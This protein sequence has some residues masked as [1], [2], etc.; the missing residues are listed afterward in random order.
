MPDPNR[1]A[2][3]L[4]DALP[5]RYDR[6]AE[7]LSFGQN[8]RWRRAMCDR[9]VS[10]RA[11]QPTLLLDVASG[12]AGVAIQLGRRSRARIVG[13]DL[14]EPMLRRGQENV[15]RAGM[16]GRVSLAVGRAERLPFR[17]ATFEGLC[18]T[19]LLRYVADPQATLEEMVR[20][21][22][23]GATVASLEFF[24]PPNG[25]WRACWW[26]YH[27]VRASRGRWIDGWPRMVGSRP[28]PRAEHLRPLSRVP[29]ALAHRGVGEGGS[30]RRRR[31][32][33][34]PGGWPRDVGGQAACLSAIVGR[35]L[36]GRERR[37]GAT[38]GRCCTRRTR[39]GTFPTSS[40]ARRSRRMSI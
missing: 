20:V 9:I 34:E 32:D 23:P 19:Y 28:I 13:V 10:T 31:A 16:A 39:R 27:A 14:T 36:R 17:D 3:D 26:L 37:A 22:K 6:L 21:V 29:V 7:V 2:Q 33:H 30:G 40:S 18:F 11:T 24:V 4:F 12:T 38:G 15:A 35:V 5:D 1:V 8:R 25:F